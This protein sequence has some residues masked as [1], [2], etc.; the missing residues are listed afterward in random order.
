[1]LFAHSIDLQPV[2]LTMIRH[3]QITCLIIIICTL[4]LMGC[5]NPK[6]EVKDDLI[7]HEWVSDKLFE[8]PD[9]RS[10]LTF[11]TDMEVILFNAPS[12]SNVKG[13]YEIIGDTITIE[14][15]EDTL[16]FGPKKF[17]LI[18]REGYLRH[19]KSG[20][21]DENGIENE[22]PRLKYIKR[23]KSDNSY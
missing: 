2:K 11:Y 10:K 19:F 16:W 8:L 18:Y 9:Y 13:T 12:V 20:F 1:M 5:S 22:S 15:Q 7:I 4:G 6:T 3:N 23:K 14:F 21:D 17:H